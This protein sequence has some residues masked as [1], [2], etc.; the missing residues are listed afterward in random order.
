MGY[1]KF[2]FQNWPTEYKWIFLPG[3]LRS[4]K[5]KAPSG[6][7]LK[8][9]FCKRLATCMHSLFSIPG[10]ILGIFFL[11]QKPFLGLM[12]S[13]DVFYTCILFKPILWYIDWAMA[14]PMHEM[15]VV[16]LDPMSL[17]FIWEALPFVTIINHNHDFHWFPLISIKFPAFGQFLKTSCDFATGHIQHHPANTDQ[18][19]VR[20][21]TTRS[22]SEHSFFFARSVGTTGASGRSW[23]SDLL[24]KQNE[25]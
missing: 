19:A 5:H 23:I 25:A 8:C 16:G 9:W 15:I 24:F 18:Q 21:R 11:W 7:T 14:D 10:R 3:V 22:E 12:M 20:P 2:V 17:C 13:D 1:D 6:R 4:Q